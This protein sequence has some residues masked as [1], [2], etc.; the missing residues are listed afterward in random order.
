MVSLGFSVY[1]IMP[2]TNSDSS[3][4]SLPV[5]IPS[6]SFSCLIAVIRTFNMMLNKIDESRHLC[7]VPDLKENAFSC[8]PLS[9]VV[10]VCLSY[11]DYYVE[12][13]SLYMH[14]VENFY[15]KSMLI[16][17]KAFYTSLEMFICFLFFSLLT[18]HVTLINSCMLN[19]PD[20]RK[21]WGQEEKGATEDEMVG[22]HH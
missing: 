5:W 21:D 7:L 18:R 17:S 4:F 14:V 2:P 22:W 9:M 12:V 8:S 20:A 3:A 6:L 16:L 10:T 13:C 11:T 15:Y 1:N 19:Y